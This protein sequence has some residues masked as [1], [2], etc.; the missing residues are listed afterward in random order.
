M[1]RW[2]T[3]SKKEWD[4]LSSLQDTQKGMRCPQF[5]TG[6]TKRNEM[7]SVPYRTHK[8]EWDVL[9]SLQDTQ[10]GMNVLSSLQDTQKGMRCPQFLTGHT[11]RNEMS[12]VPYRTHEIINDNLNINLLKINSATYFSAAHALIKL[13]QHWQTLFLC[14]GRHSKLFQFLKFNFVLVTDI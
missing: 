1:Q 14:N 9:S 2:D 6:H 11:K 3:D 5:L 4:V 12:S 7:S 13:C 10:K 8:K